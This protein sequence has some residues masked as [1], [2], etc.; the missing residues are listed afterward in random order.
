MAITLGIN[1]NADGLLL[2][3]GGMFTSADLP[4]LYVWASRVARAIA[5]VHTET[6]TKAKDLI[7]IQKLEGYKDPEVL[8]ILAMLMKTDN[9]HVYKTASFGG[10]LGN[11][12][13]EELIKM[14][15]G[16]DN[17]KNFKTEVEARAWLDVV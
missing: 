13:A 16:R 9:P 15:A 14:M 8:T 1:E 17:L 4:A 5:K 6:N 11:E 2:T 7:D 3:I 12:M 10:S